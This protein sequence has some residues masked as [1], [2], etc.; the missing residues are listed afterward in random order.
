MSIR[1][2][3]LATSI[4]AFA[5]IGCSDGSDGLNDTTNP[6][7]S[8]AGSANIVET[9]VA[10]GTF[11]TLA[12]A[13]EATGLNTVLADESATYTVFAPNDDAFAALGQETIDALLADPDTLRDIL[14]YHVIAGQAVDANTAIGLAGSTVTMANNDDVALTLENGDLFVNE[15]KVIGTDI[16][17]SNGIIHV[18]DSV[19]L[20]PADEEDPSTLPNIVETAVAAGNF[21]TLVAALQATGLDQTLANADDSFTVFAPNDDAFAKLGEDTIN[22]LLADTDTLRDILLYHVIGGAVVDSTTALSLTDSDVQMANGDTVR[23]SLDGERLLVNMSEVIATDL[24]ASNGIIHVIDTVLLPPAD[25][26]PETDIPLS[27]LLDTA[28]NQGNLNTLV[29]AL[30]AT[31][32]DVAI[33]HGNDMY[34]VFAPTDDAFAALGQDTIDALLADTD[35]LSNIL[36]YHVIAGTAVDSTTATGLVGVSIEAANGDRFSLSSRNGY[37]YINDSKIITTDIL[38]S[39]G[40]IHVIDAVLIPPVH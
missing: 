2:L 18:I 24:R 40:I 22:A 36:L 3:I 31:G 39:N 1:S 29:A 20:P 14:L 30:E 5:L 38:A 28:R 13:L 25:T 12:A 6:S 8:E 7:Q 10:A 21:T 15:A 26:V 4:S 16:F 27:N 19:L 32:L 34:T 9:A 17:A 33:G 23:L 37:L 35:T 11:N